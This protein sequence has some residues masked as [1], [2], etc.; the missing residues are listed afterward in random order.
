MICNICLKDKC[1]HT[2]YIHIIMN[3]IVYDNKICLVVSKYMYIGRWRDQLNLTITLSH[4]LLNS[5]IFSLNSS[6]VN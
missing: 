4:G 1:V 3:M 6:T 2:L 5:A